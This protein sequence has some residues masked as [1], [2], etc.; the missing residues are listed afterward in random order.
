[1][2]KATVFAPA[3]VANVAVGFD[4]LG[5]A[6]ACAGDLVT[7]ERVERPGV[8]L[9][10]A[11][12]LEGLPRDAAANT[13]TA[14]LLRLC[15]DLGLPFGFRVSIEKGIAVGSGMGGSA[16]S[17]VGG[18]VAANALLDSPLPPEVLLPYALVG[19]AVASGGKHADNVAPCLLG[20]LQLVRSVDPLDV[21]ALPVPPALHCVLVHPSV[22]VETQQ[23]RA[24]L[25]QEL[26]LRT[27]VQQSANLA[28]FVAACA[29]GD[30]ALLGRACRDVL[31]EPQR[32]HLIP[33]FAAVQR[34]AL[35]QGALA[36]SISGSGPSVFALVGS[37]DTGE[38]VK[39]AMVH[40]FGQAGLSDVRAW[41]TALS[42]RGAEVR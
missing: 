2:R 21:V 27:H 18:V 30:W 37:P 23:A 1:M 7:V 35:E 32:A 8:E 39:R 12:G 24:L 29:R 11:K 15:A 28:A 38:R 19:E 34:A 41:V 33:G 6:V 3:T 42:E 17:A 9:A 16:A 10:G 5:F 13:A 14:G 40:A 22:R 31:I 20:G 25:R 36:C 4:C 26:P